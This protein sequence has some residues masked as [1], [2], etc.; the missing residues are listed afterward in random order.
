[1]ELSQMGCGF[2]QSVFARQP[3]QVLVGTLHVGVAPRQAILFVPEHWAHRPEAAHAGLAPPQSLSPSHLQG[4]PS[5]LS[6]HSKMSCSLISRFGPVEPVKPPNAF[7]PSVP[8]RSSACD[9]RGAPGLTAV[10]E[11]KTW[12]V[13]ATPS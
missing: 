4:I 8:N 10:C 7:A 6:S 5:V 11:R 12:I 13:F 1:M 2:A 9:K 3:T